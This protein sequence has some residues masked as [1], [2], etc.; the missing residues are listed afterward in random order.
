MLKAT[1]NNVCQANAVFDPQSNTGFFKNKSLL[2]LNMGNP[3]PGER[4]SINLTDVFHTDRRI[5][6]ETPTRD[7]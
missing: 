4:N 5:A 6:T 1:A 2:L 7:S 3:S